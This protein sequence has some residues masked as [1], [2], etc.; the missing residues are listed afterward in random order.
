[1]RTVKI[2]SGE[3]DS[4]STSSI[5]GRQAIETF[6]DAANKILWTSYS[7][8][9]EADDLISCEHVQ[10][11]QVHVSRVLHLLIPA[12]AEYLS[13]LTSL[14]TNQ[15]S[16]YSDTLKRQTTTTLPLTARK[17]I[18]PFS[19]SYRCMQLMDTVSDLMSPWTLN[20]G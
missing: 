7:T 2:L 11:G 8:C 18:L 20:R 12:S 10:K 14:R 1:M 4:E 6:R 17:L 19:L 9:V 3:P 13:C 16:R 15:S 5:Y